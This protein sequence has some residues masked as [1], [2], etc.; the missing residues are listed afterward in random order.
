MTY[1]TISLTLC[2]KVIK[3][4]L[5]ILTSTSLFSSSESRERTEERRSMSPLWVPPPILS[6]L[7]PGLTHRI[8]SRIPKQRPVVRPVT[9]S[10]YWYDVCDRKSV[11]K[12]M[13][14]GGQSGGVLSLGRPLSTASRDPPSLTHPPL[15]SR[16]GRPITAPQRYIVVIVIWSS[17]IRIIA[18]YSFHLGMSASDRC[19]Y[20]KFK[21][22]NKF[23]I[24]HS[25]S[26]GKIIAKYAL[27]S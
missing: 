8:S 2:L 18:S 22:N 1:K 27:K 6:P 19:P 4:K 13:I 11:V 26:W 17:Y 23:I 20:L 25:R 10:L 21:N 7:L 9:A 24:K 12:E 16:N 5:G 3:L 14:K 15:T